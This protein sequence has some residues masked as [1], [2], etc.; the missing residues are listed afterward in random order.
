PS[1]IVTRPHVYL[2]QI[3]VRPCDNPAGG[4]SDVKQCD[5]H[6]Q[7]IRAE[8]GSVMFHLDG[9]SD[10]S[11]EAAG[12]PGMTFQHRV[13][14][15]WDGFVEMKGPRMTRLVLS[16]HGSERLKAGE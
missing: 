3:D 16:A 8:N 5:F 14:L 11:S 1:R 12:L 15:T 6:A 7:R 10:V 2:G 9:K 4:V 13:T